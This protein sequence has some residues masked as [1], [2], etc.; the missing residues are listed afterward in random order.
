ME[1][2][3]EIWK[4]VV[5]YEGLYRISSNGAVVCYSKMGR[6]EKILTAY[7]SD[8][9]YRKVAL[10]KNGDSK[11]VRLHRIIAI[12]FIPNPNNH[13]FI[14]HIN[15]IKTDNRI[16]NLEWVTASENMKHAHATG[17]KAR[18][19]GY[20]LPI[21]QMD[22]NG[23]ILQEFKSIKDACTSLGKTNRTIIKALKG[24]IESAH[25]FKWKYKTTH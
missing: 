15:G 25:G 8:N 23:A 10:C 20:W 7:L 21:Y 9:G 2:R 18:T 12:A 6:K 11:H 22:M 3:I 17:L 16:E 19:K 1:N 13:K 14:N 24:R 5:G 4:D